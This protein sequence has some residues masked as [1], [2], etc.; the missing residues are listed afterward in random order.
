[1]KCQS[2]GRQSQTKYCGDCTN[3][4]GDLKSFEEIVDNLSNYFVET[5]GFDPEAAKSAAIGVMSRQPAWEQKIE[6][7][8]R[9]KEMRT[10]LFLIV[11]AA[12]FT[13]V[14][15]GVA[16][17]FGTKTK[18]DY[19]IRFLN[20]SK[21]PQAPFE[22]IS[23]TKV[24]QFDVYEMMCPADQKL[25]ELDGDYLTIKS[26][27]GSE[28][29]PDNQLYTYNMKSK[30][31]YKFVPESLA[32][33]TQH[34][35]KGSGLIFE[36]AV[37]GEKVVWQYNPYNGTLK[38][39]PGYLFP[40]Y[41]NSK[42]YTLVLNP[43]SGNIINKRTGESKIIN[44][45]VS[46]NFAASDKY[47]VY[48]DLNKSIVI[49]QGFDGKKRIFTIQNKQSMLDWFICNNR[50]AVSAMPHEFIN[51]NYKSNVVAETPINVYDYE[52][53]TQKNIFMG[54]SFDN[55]VFINKADTPEE[56]VICWIEA[57]LNKGSTKE[58]PKYIQEPTE[59]MVWGSSEWR[60]MD[61][62]YV[63]MSNPDKIYKVPVPQGL[64][65]KSLFPI[66][67]TSNY[68][69][70]DAYRHFWR[71]ASNTGWTRGTVSKWGLWVY[72][73]K[74]NV[75]IQLEKSGCDNV[76]VDG[77]TIAWDKYTGDKNDQYYNVKF[78]YIEKDED[79]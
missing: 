9:G 2:C 37:G 36:K 67:V 3:E 64:E 51:E 42:K 23:K 44:E 8:Q 45:D 14:G 41:V 29:S 57:R 16:Y 7:S 52:T 19:S 27:E 4:N 62:Y 40:Y 6:R 38:S 60:A 11:T 76:A 13:V 22:N 74:R 48:G 26:L 43:F 34:I 59:G 12:V 31:G 46:S 28:F 73:I 18:A 75:N 54:S 50:Y 65:K 78:A 5:Q 58:K 56:T 47:Y 53:G 20:F 15:A 61:L 49:L 33:R 63:R 66:A 25:V 17:W 70:W 77:E 71:N 1:M 72:D 79:K 21:L 10:K 24:D 68:I 30:T 69:V 32:T 55:F 35:S 39:I